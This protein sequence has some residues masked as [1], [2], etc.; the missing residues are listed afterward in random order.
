VKE[1]KEAVLPASLNPS[2]HPFALTATPNLDL[3]KKQRTYSIDETREQLRQGRPVH[4]EAITAGAV[5]YRSLMYG[6]DGQQITGATAVSHTSTTAQQAT[7]TSEQQ[8]VAAPHSH[9]KHAKGRSNSHGEGALHGQTPKKISA[10]SWAAMVKSSAAAT[11]A[12]EVASPV[13]VQ[14]VR[15]AAAVKPVVATGDVAKKTNA[16]VAKGG[17]RK[18][19]AAKDGAARGAVPVDGVK[20]DRKKPAAKGDAAVKVRVV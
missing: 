1:V 19:P 12:A 15:P 14:V 16:V 10:S 3:L 13:K 9:S 11:S 8:P 4:R 5:D 17:D 18:K 7:V 20:R 6:D 2:N